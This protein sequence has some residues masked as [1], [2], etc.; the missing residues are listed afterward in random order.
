LSHKKDQTGEGL[1][2]CYANP[3][4]PSI[5]LFLSLGLYLCTL[6]CMNPVKRPLFPGTN[7]E[8]RFRQKMKAAL[9]TEEGRS[10]LKKWNR[11]S[12]RYWKPFFAKR[13]R[14]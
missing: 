13:K 3:Y 4:N 1:K 8:E 12:I 9:N 5:C 7:Q 10:Q 6:S 2:H 14:Y 11:L